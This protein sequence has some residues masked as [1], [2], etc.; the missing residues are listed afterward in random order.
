MRVEVENCLSALSGKGME[1]LAVDVMHPG[2]RI[3]AF[4]TLIPGTHF[5]ERAAGTSVGMFCA[6]L[7]SQNPDSSWALARLQ[8]M[9]RLLP[10]K[11]YVQF[12][13]GTCLLSLLQPEQALVHLDRALALNPKE[14][15]IPGIQVYRGVCLKELERY[16][17]ALATLERAEQ[18]DPDRTDVHN[19][20]GFCCFMLKKHERAIE[21]FR[22]V[23]KLNPASAIDYANIGSNYRE[24]GE[25]AKAVAYY[26]TALELDPGIEFARDNLERLSPLAEKQR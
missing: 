22:K 4:Y 1:V 25:Y 2:L 9:D 21:H 15:D 13:L 6:K 19:L 5:R 20:M 18:C 12:Y 10:G 7:I 14:E 26:R 23:L 24:M 17:E 3:P 11:Y 16:G 8:E